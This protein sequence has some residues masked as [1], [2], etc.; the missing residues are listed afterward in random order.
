ML[1]LMKKI[2][3]QNALGNRNFDK[4]LNK[5]HREHFLYRHIELSSNVSSTKYVFTITKYG[6]MPQGKIAFNTLQVRLLF[7]NPVFLKYLSIF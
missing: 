1:L 4:L 3:I 5:Y 6:L 2:L 7:L